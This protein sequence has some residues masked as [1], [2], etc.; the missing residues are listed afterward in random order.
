M[1]SL[2][3]KNKSMDVV[4]KKT[5]QQYDYEIIGSNHAMTRY[6]ILFILYNRLWQDLDKNT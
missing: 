2:L 6:D 5:T 1:S 3:V 4:H